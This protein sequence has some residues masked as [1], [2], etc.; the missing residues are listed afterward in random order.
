MN[1][2]VRISHTQ[3]GLFIILGSD[4]LWMFVGRYFFTAAKAAA[5]ARK[6]SLSVEAL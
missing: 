6:H 2:A 4:G 1:N 3:D 5:F